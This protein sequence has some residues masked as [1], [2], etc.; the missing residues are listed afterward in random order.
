MKDKINK[1]KLFKGDKVIW[2][3][4]ALLSGISLLAVYSATGTLAFLKSQN[5][6]YFLVKRVILIFFFF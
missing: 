3:I 5:K 2:L 1:L 6:A 4:V